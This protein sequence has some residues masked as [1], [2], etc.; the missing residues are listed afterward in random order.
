MQLVTKNKKGFEEF[1]S[2]PSVVQQRNNE[3]F[4]VGSNADVVLAFR[5]IRCSVDLLVKCCS[6]NFHIKS[7]QKQTAATACLT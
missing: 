3:F 5:S 7:S 4:G 2:V 1:I 6:T